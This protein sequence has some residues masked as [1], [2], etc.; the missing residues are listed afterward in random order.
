MVEGRGDDLREVERGEHP[1][2]ELLADD[3]A[4]LVGE[5]RDGAGDRGDCRDSPSEYPMSPS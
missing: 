5:R 3:R 1:D 2:V 4:L